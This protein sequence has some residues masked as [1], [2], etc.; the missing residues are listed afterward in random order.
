[1]S[2]RCHCKVPFYR[3]VC[4]ALRGARRTGTHDAE[5]A[6]DNG[7]LLR[8]VTIV[9]NPNVGK[10]VLFNRLTG[11]YVVVSNYPGT[12]VE[13]S[14]ARASFGGVPFEVVDTPGMYSLRPLS[15]EERVG[16][17]ILLHEPSEIVVH[18]MDA[19]NLGRMLPFTLQLLEAGLEVVPV[20]NMLDEAERLGLKVDLAELSRGLGR[21]VVGT[22]ALSGRGIPELRRSIDELVNGRAFAAVAV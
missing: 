15:D 22:V 19:K 18:V 1:M 5:R 10:S 21:G 13:V 8:R 2:G 14:R 4:D 17:A 9:G 20:V 11:S 3:I 16:R 12:T 7:A 6:D